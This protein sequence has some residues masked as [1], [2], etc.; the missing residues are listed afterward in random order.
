ML[1][2]LITCLPDGSVLH[3]GPC[4]PPPSPLEKALAPA[5]VAD[6]KSQAKFTTA[7]GA[8]VLDWTG[9]ASLGLG[10]AT[11]WLGPTP[12]MTMV[13]LRGTSPKAIELARGFTRGWDTSDVVRQLAK[14]RPSFTSYLETPD[15][16]LGLAVNWT[17][18]PPDELARLGEPE[19]AV[20]S[21]FFRN[22]ESAASL[23]A[24][25]S[26]F[27]RLFGGS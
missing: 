8:V 10:S 1:W 9:N 2:R 19:A 22:L 27:K 12:A 23:P 5:I 6:G 17:V 4:D 18:I 21:A 13:Y 3:D 25:P 26:L 16:P 11:L 20:G 15:R 14:G 7:S 24:A